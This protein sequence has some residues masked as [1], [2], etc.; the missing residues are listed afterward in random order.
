MKPV[1][2]IST[3]GYYDLKTGKTLKKNNYYLYPKKDFQKLIDSKELTIMIHGLR[4]D[5]AGAIAK[6]VLAR[7]R[8]RKLG[9]SHPVIGFSYDSNTTGAHLIKHAKHALA[10]GQN[11]AKKNGR[12]LGK[13]IEDFKA[14]SPKTKIRL[15]GHS[16]GSQVILS[17]IEYLAKKKQNSGILESIYFFGASITEDV[18][19]SKKYGK[20]LQTIVR[21]KIMNHYAPS[22]EVLSWADDKK[23]V[24]GPLGLNGAIGKPIKKYHQKLVKPK[25]HRFASYAAVL[26]TFP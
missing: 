18:P 17:T 16:L 10:V 20:S 13:F 19:S 1:P 3:R 24:L 9:Y 7:N 6:A 11:I 22:D 2:R 15:M 21:K 8:L 4:N 26:N 5:N 25:N 23:Y 12:H 14:S